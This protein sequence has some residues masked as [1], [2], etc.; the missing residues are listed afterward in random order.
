MT[1]PMV[2]LG[3]FIG[4]KVGRAIGEI[5]KVIVFAITVAWSIYTTAK[6]AFDLLKKER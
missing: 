6:K 4:V 1:M 2:F 5:P 3:S